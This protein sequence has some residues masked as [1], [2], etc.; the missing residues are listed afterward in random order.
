VHAGT[1]LLRGDASTILEGVNVTVGREV[2]NRYYRNVSDV[3]DVTAFHDLGK[4]VASGL[5]QGLGAGR[6]ARYVATEA[7][8]ESAASAMSS[9]E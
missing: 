3:S 2:T 9:R 8:I 5:L 1:L 7:L 6:S 4:L